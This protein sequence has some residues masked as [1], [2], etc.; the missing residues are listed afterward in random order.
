MILTG[1]TKEFGENPVPVPLCPPQIS[2]GLTW[3][4]TQASVVT[5]QQLTTCVSIRPIYIAHE[6]S[7]Y[8]DSVH[9]SQKMLCASVRKNNQCMFFLTKAQTKSM[10]KTGN[11]NNVINNE[12]IAMKI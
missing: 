5:G 7:L 2:H 12:N 1:K 10:Y 3:D 6:L 4:Q 8:K 11:V 9:T